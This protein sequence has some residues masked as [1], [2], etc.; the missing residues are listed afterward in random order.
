MCG[1]D[2]NPLSPSGPSIDGVYA[3][4]L[5]TTCDAVPPGQRT[6]DY[7]A[8]ISGSP[9]ATMTLSNATFWQHPTEGLYNKLTVVQRGKSLT[10]NAQRPPAVTEQTGP[11]TFLSFGGFGSGEV[12][13]IG[14]LAE[15]LTASLPGP[16][17][18]GEDVENPSRHHQCGRTSG[19]VTLHLRS[20][21]RS[22][23]PP[24]IAHSIVSAEI[25]G[26]ST[27]ATGGS[28][29]FGIV[30]RMTD[31][32]TREIAEGVSWESTD[33]SVLGA[34][35]S[36][37]AV[38][39]GTGEAILRANVTRPN[40]SAL[41]VTREVIVVPDGTFRVAGQVTE[42]DD[43]SVPIVNARVEVVSAVPTI[44]TTTSSQGRYRLYGVRPGSEIRISQDGY[45]PRVM[46]ATAAEHQTLNTTLR[47][48][49]PR[50]ELSGTYT[51]TITA[52]CESGSLPL[53][54]RERKY[55]AT[56]SQRGPILSVNLS[57]ANFKAGGGHAFTGQIEPGRATFWLW[58]GYYFDPAVIEQLPDSFLI[59]S[60]YATTTISS[61]SLV[62]TMPGQIDQVT[63]W[64]GTVINRC[65]SN[66]H[67]FALTR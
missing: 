29:Q 42:D 54:L 21:D 45:E 18:F 37:V 26:P 13:G 3:L 7:I 23:P 53:E 24:K 64:P 30:A 44:A 46:Q 14:L 36:G 55:T 66:A 35:N 34:G 40:T 51:L 17:R 27:V 49:Q 57:G 4:R 1:T 28:A 6:R 59:V 61:N 9:N 11:G 48:S 41:P 43:H 2:P 56:I 60:G 32:S 8:T 22:A 20:T 52:M 5:E 58:Y 65:W 62:G 19:L 16:V 50:P 67:K 63:N 33:A 10:V 38:G 47:V 31:G 15:G 12:N 39:S 25:T